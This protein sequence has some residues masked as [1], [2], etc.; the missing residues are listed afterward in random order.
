MLKRDRP[1][2]LALTSNEEVVPL[3]VWVAL[4]EGAQEGMR[5]CCC[6]RIIGV[7]VGVVLAV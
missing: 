3:K 7:V 2:A 6:G 4:E 1:E 5:V